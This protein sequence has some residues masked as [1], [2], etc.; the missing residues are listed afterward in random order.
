MVPILALTIAPCALAQSYWIDRV[1]GNPSATDDGI[2]ATEASLAFPSDVAV[3]TSGSFY[4]AD[5]GDHRIRKVD[6]GLFKVQISEQLAATE[7]DD[8]TNGLGLWHNA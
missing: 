8:W 1:A 3:G 2:P 6:A 5:A 7:G 4:I